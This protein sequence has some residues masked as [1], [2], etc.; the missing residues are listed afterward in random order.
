MDMVWDP[1]KLPL[2]AHPN[3]QA[4]EHDD[5]VRVAKHFGCCN[6]GNPVN[7]QSRK[8]FDAFVVN[9][10]KLMGDI[11]CAIQRY[12]ETCGG[13][14]CAYHDA[15]KAYNDYLENGDHGIDIKD[16]LLIDPV[17]SRGYIIDVRIIAHVTGETVGQ[18]H[19]SSHCSV[20][21]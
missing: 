9:I 10:V 19:S 16:E 15:V 20:C 3:F 12:K 11:N 17:M 6:R 8:L 1:P 2:R 14:R 18:A 21:H 7:E 4:S 13:D 5:P